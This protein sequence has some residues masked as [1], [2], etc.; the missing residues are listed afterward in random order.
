MRSAPGLFPANAGADNDVHP[1]RIGRH[2]NK[3]ARDNLG[4]ESLLAFRRLPGVVISP[5][6]LGAWLSRCPDSQSC[7]DSTAILSSR[8]TASMCQARPQK[9]ERYTGRRS[10]T[11]IPGFYL[12]RA[13]RK[14][15]CR[16]SRRGQQYS[17]PWIPIA[18]AT[19]PAFTSCQRFAD[20]AS[21][22]RCSMGSSGIPDVL[23]SCGSR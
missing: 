11:A 22:R 16:L 2:G 23:A 10:D 4:P 14:S 20:S 8:W 3:R 12:R 18:S 15:R 1:F 17:C 19:P 13:I 7:D 5:R 9:H 21:S 6:A